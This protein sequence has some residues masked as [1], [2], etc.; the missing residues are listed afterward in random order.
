[1]HD[2]RVGRFFATDPLFKEYPHNSVYAF[3]ENRIMDAVELEGKEAFFIHGTT[4]NNKRWRNEDNTLKEGTKQ[5]FRL[6]NSKYINTGFE[7][8][9]FLN[10]GN[11]FFN[12]I[13]DRSEAALELT[14]YIMAKRIKGEDITLIA[15]SH[16]GNVAIQAAPILKAALYA[17]GE[18][19]VKINIIT[20]ATPAVNNPTSLENPEMVE[21]VF[22]MLGK[23]INTHIHIYN[24]QDKVQTELANKVDGENYERYYKNKATINVRLDVL[25]YF[26][27]ITTD[28]H[29]VDHDKP[30]VIKEN[31]DNGTIPKI[32]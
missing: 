21:K 6:Q 14:N 25:D 31:I 13:E 28:A 18:K 12:D 9:G 23:I 32:E 11:N 2:P 16:G 4:S 17:V 5:L 26:E 8:G 7:W 20:I 10:Y 3:S 19:D 27:G 30:E 1:M 15:H 24:P 22:P 29:S